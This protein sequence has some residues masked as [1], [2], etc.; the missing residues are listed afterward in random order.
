MKIPH[1]IMAGSLALAL[2]SC[3]EKKQSDVIIVENYEASRT[4]GPHKDG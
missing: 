2:A 1:L 3:G 4:V